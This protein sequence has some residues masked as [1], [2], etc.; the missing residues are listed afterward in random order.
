MSETAVAARPMAKS[1]GMGMGPS[2]KNVATKARARPNRVVLYAVEGWGKSSWGCM[3]PSPI[4]LMTKGEDGL[5]KLIENGLV[6]ETPH[7]DDEATTWNE[8]LLGVRALL[9]DE[10]HGYKTL[11]LDVLNG[12]AKLCVDHVCRTNFGGDMEK[13]ND[14]GRGWKIV[15]SEWQKFLDLLTQVNESGMT[16]LCLAHADVKTFKNPEGP[17]FDQ[18]VPRM[19]PQLWEPTQ[20]WSDMVLFGQLET[21]VAG[22]KDVKKKG[23]GVGGQDRVIR[24]ERTAT[25]VAKHR[26]GLPEII[27]CG[28]GAKNAWNA[29]AAALVAGR[30]KAQAEAKGEE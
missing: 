19:P 16:V 9:V 5:R 17:D 22:E 8:L 27:P 12:A 26:H 4:F 23:K 28:A 11:V 29:F 25:A 14:Y 30:Q 3:T 20:E 18:Y 1:K 7:F 24:C 15:P 21:F 13:F 10:A 6:P 2:L